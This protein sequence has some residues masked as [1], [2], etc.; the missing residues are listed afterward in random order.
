MQWSFSTDVIHDL[1]NIVN[2]HTGQRS[3][4]ISDEHYQIIIKNAD[5]INS[6][7]IYDRD[8][9]YNYFGFK[10]NYIKHFN[11]IVAIL[12]LFM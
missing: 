2:E 6:A 7:I 3:P 10:V 8:F 11:I 4:M 9:N 5:R 1:Y 12:I